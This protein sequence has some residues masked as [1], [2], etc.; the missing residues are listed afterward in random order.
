MI[1][2]LKSKNTGSIII[3]GCGGDEFCYVSVKV[4]VSSGIWM[5]G[6]TMQ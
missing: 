1:S 5:G 6:P 4:E 2:F 3:W